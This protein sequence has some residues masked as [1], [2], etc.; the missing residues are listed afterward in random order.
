MVSC[1]M[2]GKDNLLP[3]CCCCFFFFSEQLTTLSA[4][5]NK[6]RS[7]FSDLGVEVINMH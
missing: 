5:S 6:C 3:V 4:H 2:H 1:R 7:C